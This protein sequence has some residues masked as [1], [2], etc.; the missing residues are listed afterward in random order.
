[1]PPFDTITPEER[2]ALQRIAML[3]AAGFSDEEIFGGLG[4]A[5]FNIG[6]GYGYLP[7]ITDLAG[8][9]S[10]YNLGRGNL[11]LGAMDQFYRNVNNPYNVVG[12]TQYM[13][14][15]GASPFLTDPVLG[16]VPQSP[17]GR[18]QDYLDS[19]LF[20]GGEA[21]VTGTAPQTVPAGQ[22]ADF[23]MLPVGAGTGAAAAPSVAPAPAA[24]PW[25]PVGAQSASARNLA[26]T[27]PG[28]RGAQYSQTLGRGEI[29]GFSSIAPADF[30]RMSSDQQAQ[31]L[32]MVQSTG[33]VSDAQRAYADF[34]RRY[35]PG[36]SSFAGV[37]R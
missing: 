14:D 30:G 12:A 10:S 25:S 19:L 11:A 35:D 24:A 32:G 37:Y 33:R 5:P 17:M 26:P 1:M 15:T 4:A 29:P 28:M 34:L 9:T 23:N 21:G 18:Y 13:R 2:A 3:R 20:P 7:T 22:P 27:L 8:I 36:G 31:Y 16:N 6:G